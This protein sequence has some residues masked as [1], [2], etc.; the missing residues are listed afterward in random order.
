MVMGFIL[1]WD[2]SIL[3][4]RCLYSIECFIATLIDMQQCR[5]CMQIHNYAEFC[6]FTLLLVVVNW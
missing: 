1:Q 4:G 5:S 3:V 6:S 2:S